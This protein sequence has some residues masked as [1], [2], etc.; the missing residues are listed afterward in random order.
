MKGWVNF[1]NTKKDKGEEVGHL[2]HGYYYAKL[3]ITH[4][5]IIS[6]TSDLP[7]SSAPPS[8]WQ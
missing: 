3:N 1:I 6:R 4:V 7:L 8:K 5:S 2:I